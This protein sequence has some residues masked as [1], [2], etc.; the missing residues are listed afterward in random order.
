MHQQQPAP[1]TSTKLAAV[2]FVIA[3]VLFLAG[4]L[5]GMAKPAFGL[6]MAA[7]YLLIAPDYWRRGFMNTATGAK[8]TR[9]LAIAGAAS[10]LAGVSVQFGWL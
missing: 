10:I 4:Y 6:F 2:A 1:L 8:L 7:G 5:H 9:P 3:G